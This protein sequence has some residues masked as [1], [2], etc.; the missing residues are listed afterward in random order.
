MR[1]AAL[2]VDGERTSRAETRRKG[3]RG[4]GGERGREEVMRQY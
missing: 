3:E 4:G 2:Q 1:C